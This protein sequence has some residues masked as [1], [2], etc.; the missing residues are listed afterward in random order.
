MAPVVPQQWIAFLDADEEDFIFWQFGF[1]KWGNATEL[2]WFLSAET[3]LA[4]VTEIK[5]KPKA[6]ILDGIVP[7]GSEKAWL[8][9]FLEHVCCQD[10]P[11]YLLSAQY[12][13]KDK[14]DYLDLGAAE[15]LI[16]PNT[17]EELQHTVRQVMTC[18]NSWHKGI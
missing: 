10:I 3:F 5:S 7:Y 2:H 16:K 11:I 14:K 4:N 9:T 1:K 6:M 17:A 8:T 18:L 13:S 15:Y 12:N